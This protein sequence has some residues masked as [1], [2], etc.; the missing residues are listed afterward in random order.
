MSDITRYYTEDYLLAKIEKGQRLGLPGDVRTSEAL[1]TVP[2]AVRPT[3]AS[4]AS[5]MV[6]TTPGWRQSSAVWYFVEQYNARGE[7]SL[8]AELDRK[9]R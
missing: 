7:S 1:L 6:N 9:V 8:N 2:I 5:R 4:L 3:I